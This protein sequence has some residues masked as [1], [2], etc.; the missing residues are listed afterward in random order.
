[1]LYK[2]GMWG[3]PQNHRTLEMEAEGLEVQGHPLLYSEFDA[4][5]MR[6]QRKRM[7]RGRN[8]QRKGGGREGGKGEEELES[9]FLNSEHASIEGEKKLRTQSL[10][11]LRS[12]IEGGGLSRCFPHQLYNK[13]LND[14]FLST[15]ESKF[16]EM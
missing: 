2:L 1:M 4:G 12:Y 15:S 16:V 5:H 6:P 13:V 10:C 8:G 11:L 9:V 3:H 14:W 7:G